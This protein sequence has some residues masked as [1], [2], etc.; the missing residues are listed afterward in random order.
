MRH[1]EM[2]IYSKM[3]LAGSVLLLLFTVMVLAWVTKMSGD[4]QGDVFVLEPL[5]PLTEDSQVS[6]SVTGA[7]A[8]VFHSVVYPSISPLFLPGEMLVDIKVMSQNN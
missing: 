5:R 2:D 8:P 4:N 7:S 6:L 1:I 3:L